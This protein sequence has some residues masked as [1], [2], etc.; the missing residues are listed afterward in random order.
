VVRSA[1]LHLRRTLWDRRVASPDRPVSWFSLALGAITL[2]TMLYAMFGG[3]D[4]ALLAD[5]GHGGNGRWIACHVVLWQVMFGGTL[6]AGS[7][8]A[9]SRPSQP[10]LQ[11]WPAADVRPGSPG[12]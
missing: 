1:R 10:S 6:M 8:M 5:L 12:R 4:A 11:T 2:G 7:K 3:L 9:G